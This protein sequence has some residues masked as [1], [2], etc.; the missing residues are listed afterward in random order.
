M[1]KIHAFLLSTLIVLFLTNT[2]ELA[3][4]EI[5]QNSLK[6]CDLSTNCVRIDWEVDSVS[7]SFKKATNIVEGME[8][9]N[10]VEENNLYL[11]AEITSRI[12][13]Y[14]DDFEIIGITEKGVLQVRS[15]SR[16]GKGDFGVNRKRV[17]NFLS[18]LNT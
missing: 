9:T 2:A 13:H 10:I 16:L 12:M 11:H 6:K 17:I 18:L 4:Q 3:A 7:N 5:Q 1:G 15:A 14:V 8:R